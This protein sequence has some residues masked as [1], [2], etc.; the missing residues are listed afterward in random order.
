[1]ESEIKIHLCFCTLPICELSQKLQNLKLFEF[2][3]AGAKQINAKW[4]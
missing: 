2:A 4:I 1:M 3:K